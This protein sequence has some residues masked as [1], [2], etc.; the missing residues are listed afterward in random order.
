[1]ANFEAFRWNFL[2][3]TNSE[4]GRSVFLLI[5]LIEEMSHFFVVLI[6]YIEYVETYEMLT[7]TNIFKEKSFC[8]FSVH[9]KKSV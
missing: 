8:K 6:T 1:M 9:D 5:Y 4:I 3:S 2:S 7:H